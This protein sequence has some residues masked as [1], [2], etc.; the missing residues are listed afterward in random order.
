MSETSDDCRK[1][2]PPTLRS[3]RNETCDYL[4]SVISYVSVTLH[5][6][7][8]TRTRIKCLVFVVR[9]CGS[10]LEATDKLLTLPYS[11]LISSPLASVFLFFFIFPIK[12]GK[13]IRM[14]NTHSMTWDIITM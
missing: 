7:F 8:S 12:P 3:A 9:R 5:L 11:N 14:L 4:I 10:A 2:S 1:A 6:E 13:T